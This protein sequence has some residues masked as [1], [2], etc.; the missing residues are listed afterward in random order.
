MIG[1][2]IQSDVMNPDQEVVK[3]GWCWRDRKYAPGDTLSRSRA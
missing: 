1:D 2:M 3:Q